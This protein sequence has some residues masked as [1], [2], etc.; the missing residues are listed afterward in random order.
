MP[1]RHEI[2]IEITEKRQD[3]VR[4]RYL[5]EYSEYTG[6]NVILSATTAVALIKLLPLEKKRLNAVHAKKKP[7]FRQP[8]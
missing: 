6:R 5:K 3:S 7:R 1:S 2:A 8:I 4:R